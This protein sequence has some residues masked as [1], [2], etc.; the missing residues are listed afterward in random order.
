MENK[1]P[2]STPREWGGRRE[3][4]RKYVRA[5]TPILRASRSACTREATFPSMVHK[6][7]RDKDVRASAGKVTGTRVASH[8][9]LQAS[10]AEIIV[11]VRREVTL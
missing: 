3:W 8:R 5:E 2:T 4:G 11:G 9:S 10:S 1:A 7:T 6:L